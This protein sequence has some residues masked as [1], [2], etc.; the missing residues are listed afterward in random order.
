M[1]QLDSLKQ[2]FETKFDSLRCNLIKNDSHFLNDPRILPCSSTACLECI[3]K[4]LDSANY[5]NCSFCRD[6]HL[7]Q[8]VQELKSNDSVIHQINLNSSDINDELIE[9][10]NKIIDR[11]SGKV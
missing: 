7:I 2:E 9:R 8:N 11:L 5:L 10:L 6:K 1:E 3:L 4:S